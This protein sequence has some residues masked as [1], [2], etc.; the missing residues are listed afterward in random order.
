M[1]GADGL[2]W[3]AALARITLRKTM[4]WHR[5]GLPSERPVDAMRVMN[6]WG[7]WVSLTPDEWRYLQ[8]DMNKAGQ[9]NWQHYSSLKIKGL[10]T[11]SP[12]A[13]KNICSVFCVRA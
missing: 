2:F 9:A 11:G 1:T 13:W 10:L 6:L 8:Y 4:S 12:E 7:E 3:S 5:W